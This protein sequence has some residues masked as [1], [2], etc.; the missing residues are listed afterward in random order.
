MKMA[1]VGSRCFICGEEGSE[2]SQKEVEI[3]R[4]LM[5]IWLIRALLFAS[6]AFADIDK[7]VSGGARGIDSRAEEWSIEH[8][9]KLAE[10]YEANWYPKGKY[11]P[12]A[13]FKRNAVV[14]DNVDFAVA[15]W[16]GH[17]GGTLDT[18][19]R[20]REAGL[21]HIILIPE[22]NV[23]DKIDHVELQFHFIE[24]LRRQYDR[25]ETKEKQTQRRR[26]KQPK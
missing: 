26:T 17:S 8:L 24:K 16:D 15:I 6:I 22:L 4:E 14:V 5:E 7:V 13:G 12:A 3:Q 19:R 2:D 25:R 1:I 10:V 21:P 20:L 18:I 9:G 23:F 11:D